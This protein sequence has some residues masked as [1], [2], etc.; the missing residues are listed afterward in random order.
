MPRPLTRKEIN[1]LDPVRDKE[2][3]L[4]FLPPP[5]GYDLR[6]LHEIMADLSHPV[7]PVLLDSKVKKGTEI[8][9][10]EWATIADLLDLYAY[11]WDWQAVVTP[12]ADGQYATCA[13][14]LIIPTSDRGQVV[15]SACGGI[16]DD[17]RQYGEPCHHAESQALRRAAGKFGL[18]RSYWHKEERTRFRPMKAKKED[19]E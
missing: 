12:S 5:A 17:E 16:E 10:I 3:F 8:I 9:F 7:H 18:M 15:R 11:G 1:A 2:Q 13:G 4:P 19:R 6:P 14:T